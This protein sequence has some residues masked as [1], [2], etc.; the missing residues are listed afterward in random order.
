MAD[1][2]NPTIDTTRSRTVSSSS[3]EL[4]P[5]NKLRRYL[6]I[7]NI[8]DTINVGVNPGGTAA[9]GTA[10]TITLLPGGSVVFEGEG[11]PQNAFNVIS[12]SGTPAVS[13]WEIT[14]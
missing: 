14:G 9:I 4:V 1:A 7:Q 11:I 8:D 5:A 2:L 3:T 13:V 6:L 10:G 12:A